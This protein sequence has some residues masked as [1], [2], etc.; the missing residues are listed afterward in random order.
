MTLIGNVTLTL[1]NNIM[2]QLINSYILGI[3]LDIKV[4]SPKHFDVNSRQYIY[5]YLM[6][7]EP[8]QSTTYN[9]IA[10][11]SQQLLRRKKREMR[12]K[13]PRMSP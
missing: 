4:F 3:T 12:G 5:V 8:T 2:G 1:I 7:I 10:A 11:S 9:S 13:S 6:C